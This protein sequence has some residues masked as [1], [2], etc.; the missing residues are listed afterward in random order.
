MEKPQPSPEKPQIPQPPTER[1]VNPIKIAAFHLK[2]TLKTALT[3]ERSPVDHGEAYYS[4]R[5]DDIREGASSNYGLAGGYEAWDNERY[6]QATIDQVREH[7]LVRLEVEPEKR[8]FRVL[9]IG[10]AYG[11]LLKYLQPLENELNIKLVRVGADISRWALTKASE[12]QGSGGAN[13]VEQNLEQGLPFASGALDITVAADVIE[14]THDRQQTIGELGRVLKPDGLLVLSVPITDTWLG[15]LLWNKFDVD[16]THVSI[17]TSGELR[18]ELAAAGFKI[19]SERG[20]FGAG[21]A[22]I[23]QLRTNL[24]VVAVKRSAKTAASSE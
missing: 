14:H 17:P 1:K 22:K 7:I 5:A 9:D 21:F 18:K 10:T 8:E 12:S 3:G 16:P 15:K 2:H 20:F 19:V 4:P 24:E 13:L 23:R 11:Y 6:W